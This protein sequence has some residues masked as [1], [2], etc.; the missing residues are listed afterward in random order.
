MEPIAGSLLVAAPTMADPNFART[1]VLLL[2]AGNDGFRVAAQERI[3]V[4]EAVEFL[5]REEAPI[6]QDGVERQ[7]AMA[8]AQDEAIT[9]PPQGLSRIVPQ[10]VVIEDAN[11][12]DQRKGRTDMASPAIF[13]G[14]K[15]QAPK[16]P[17]TLIQRLKLDRIQVGV[18]AQQNPILHAH[19]ILP[20]SAHMAVLKLA[21]VRQSW[22]SGIRVVS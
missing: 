12:L 4:A 11:H 18:I 16:M 3:V 13:D 20:K 19:T 7:T 21:L 2:D 17:A 22:E 5:E 9:P 1:I 6:R 14:A 15:N 10:K 8:L